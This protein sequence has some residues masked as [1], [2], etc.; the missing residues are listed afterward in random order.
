MGKYARKYRSSPVGELRTFALL[1]AINSAS[2]VLGW[3][4]P[5]GAGP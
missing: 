2:T 3:A 1:C 4:A 5:F